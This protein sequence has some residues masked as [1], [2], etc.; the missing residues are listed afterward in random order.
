MDLI[1]QQKPDSFYSV[2]TVDFACNIPVFVCLA[3]CVAALLT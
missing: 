3:G 1:A 2:I